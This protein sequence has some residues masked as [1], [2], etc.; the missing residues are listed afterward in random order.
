MKLRVVPPHTVE[1]SFVIELTPLEAR[2]MRELCMHIGGGNHGP[3]GLFASIGL[4]L[5]NEGVKR[6]KTSV[7][8][9]SKY[10]HGVWFTNTYPDPDMDAGEP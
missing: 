7:I 4:K 2:V 10:G 5:H 3:R 1:K 6:Y 8:P 9:K